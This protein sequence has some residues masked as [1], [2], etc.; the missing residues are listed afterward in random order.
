VSRTP[1]IFR[2]FVLVLFVALTAPRMWQR[3]MFGDGLLYATIARNLSLGAGSFWA[4]SFT[5]TRWTPFH[6][7]PPLGLVLEAGAFWLFGDSPGVERAWS[8]AIAL[9]HA[10][11]IVALWRR[12][13]SADD[14]WLPLLFW[15]L[16]SVVIWAVI[17]NMLENTQALFTSTAVLLVFVAGRA[18]RA[19]TSVLWTTLAAVAIVA[20]ALVKGP[21]GLFPIAAPATLL[22]LPQAQRPHRSRVVLITLTLLGLVA[23]AAATLMASE[24]SRFAISEYVRTHLAPALQGQRGI[25]DDASPMG[26]FLGLG[27]ILRMSVLGSVLWAVGRAVAPATPRPAGPSW[28]FLALGCCASFPLAVT[29]KLSGHYFVPSVPL[30]ALGFAALVLG[31]AQSA[32]AWLTHIATSRTRRMVGTTACALVIAAAITP[33][34][35]PRL[36]QRD[37]PLLREIDAIAGAVPPG[38]LVGVCTRAAASDWQ[39]EAYMN[40][41]HHVTLVRRDTPVNGWWLRADRSCIA[42][43][44]CSETARG[45]VFALYRCPP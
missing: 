15:M 36:R 41:L 42:P 13:L 22:L 25:A 11:V 39:L 27:I 19:D 17:N 2:S 7:Q 23:I 30:F 45:D 21:V 37:A 34:L 14:D 18:A 43:S 4:P 26:R 16:P 44:A 20:A 10:V 6:E 5:S 29:P 31:H 28:C 40:R 8:I 24:P 35:H 3:G 33:L 1:L 38:A 32:M 12:L 9:L